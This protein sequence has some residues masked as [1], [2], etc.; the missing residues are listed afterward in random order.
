MITINKI[1]S[2]KLNSIASKA[3]IVIC[4]SIIAILN[5]TRWRTKHKVQEIGA[6]YNIKVETK[7][8]EWKISFFTQRFI[9]GIYRFI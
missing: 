2:N 5:T 3:R 6:S 4:Y 1:S 7:S 9:G 8:D